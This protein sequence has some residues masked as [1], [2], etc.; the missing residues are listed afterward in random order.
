M[1]DYDAEAA[2]YDDER[3]GLAR[4]REAATAVITLAPDGG[5]YLD[6]AG[7]TG[8]VSNEVALAG[9]SVIVLDA[10]HGMLSKAAERLPGRAVQARAES[11]P[12]ASD[13]MDA[14]TAIWLL[15]LLDDPAPVVAE[16]A[17]VLRS[18]GR[19]VT[20]VDKAAAH[21]Y[22]FE[23]NPTDG[24]AR[25]TELAAA[26]GMRPAGAATF[27]GRGQDRGDGSE[28]VYTVVAFAKTSRPTDVRSVS[29]P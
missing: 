24:V 11:L 27:V 26:H 3:G 6:I 15:H 21:G 8:I 23:D 17:R 29:P 22:A 4:A 7:G 14:V 1:L 25:I 20:T 16:A 12:I 19:F 18:G 2:S 28:P 13:S 5:L 9:A 10:S